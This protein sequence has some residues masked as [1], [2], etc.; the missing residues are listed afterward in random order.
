ML[1]KNVQG[2]FQEFVAKD[3]SRFRVMIHYPN[4]ALYYEVLLS[5]SRL[6]RY[7]SCMIAIVF[8][9]FQLTDR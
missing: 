8:N 7:L 4:T 6:R 1:L 5:I 2:D 3:I 9:I